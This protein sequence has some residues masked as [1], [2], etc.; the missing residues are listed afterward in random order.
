MDDR[1]ERIEGLWLR[2][3][4]RGILVDEQ[5]R[6]LL[7]QPHKYERDRW[8]FVGGGIESGESP[9]GAMVRE[10]AE[11]VGVR[12][13]VSMTRAS[14]RPWYRFSSE[15]KSRSAG[16]DGQIASLFWVVIPSS[17]RV[18]L[19]ADEIRAHRWA[20]RDEVE[21]LLRERQHRNFLVVEAEVRGR[22]A[23]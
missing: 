15:R 22:P 8:T 18:V 6:F 20:R 4:V 7:I 10:M 14:H 1:F 5:G 16:H 13:W 3:K 12:D 23:A 19:Q 21:G 9:E 2:K 11:E 17:V